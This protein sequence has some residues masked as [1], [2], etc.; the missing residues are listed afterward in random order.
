MTTHLNKYIVEKNW[1]FL[2]KS[3]TTTFL[4]QQKPLLSYRRPKNLLDMLVKADVRTKKQ[5]SE[6][7]LIRKSTAKHFLHT[8]PE[9]APSCQIKLKQTSIRNFFH[10]VPKTTQFDEEG[11]TLTQVTTPFIFPRRGFTNLQSTHSEGLPQIQM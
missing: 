9:E 8:I 10:K 2:G 11:A 5:I 6:A 4:H 7:N 3:T 1:D